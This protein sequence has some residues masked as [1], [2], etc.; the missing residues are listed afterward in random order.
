MGTLSGAAALVNRPLAV[1]LPDL[2]VVAYNGPLLRR[3]LDDDE[4]GR[5]SVQRAVDNIAWHEYGHVLS[6]TRA[7][8]EAKRDGARLLGLLP[9]G[10]RG[11]IDYPGGYRR[12]E[13]FDE[14]IANVYAL[15]IGRAVH[16][17]DYRLPEFLHPDVRKAFLD[18]VPWPPD[19]A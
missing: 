5:R 3:A 13:V 18:V 4:L 11:A 19:A 16:D 17:G 7:S 14:V 12:G 9:V 1:W 8:P 2:H 10:L 6:A 15:M